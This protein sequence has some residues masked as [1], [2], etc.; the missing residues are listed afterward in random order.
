MTTALTPPLV[1]RLRSATW[2]RH[3]IFERL[4]FVTAMTDGTLP[5]ESYVGQLR[6]FASLFTTLESV[7][8]ESDVPWDSKLLSYLKTRFDLLC[9]DLSFFAPRMVSDIVPAIKEALE[10]SR[11]IRREAALDPEKLLGY[12]YV[13][14]GTT[15]GNQVHLPDIIR[16]FKLSEGEGTTFYRGYGEE[17]PAHW[18]EASAL[19][20]AADISDYSVVEQGAIEMYEALERFHEALLPFT[21]DSLGFTASS[22]NPEAGEHPV[23]QNS[24][25]MAAALRAGQQCREE[26]SYYEKRY[27]ER[28]RRFTASDVA[29]LAALADYSA[30][31]ALS[32]VQWLGRVLSSRGMPLLLLERQVQL[33]V[34]NMSK[35]KP[36]IHTASLQSVVDVLRTE[37]CRTI[38]QDRFDEV[39][40][41][42]DVTIFYGKIVEFSDLPAL[43]V[44]S[45]VDLMSGI[46]E[47]RALIM[48]WL[49]ETELLSSKE[50]CQVH[51]ILDSLFYPSSDT[52]TGENV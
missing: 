3:E 51:A 47:C 29:W 25:V 45:Q 33:L 41:K 7:V 23:S 1:E 24:A 40:R 50:L 52:I 6:G 31:V 20:N 42:L 28:G 44:A 32:Q 8:V 48:E 16:C 13:M 9:G 10:F 18:V 26:F 35:I 43:L 22:L 12:L 17:T 21:P 11:H 2:H 37:R 14:E 19:M 49:A 27:G 39:C 36:P 46:P 38:S 4:P 30:D 15:R 34:E 5:L